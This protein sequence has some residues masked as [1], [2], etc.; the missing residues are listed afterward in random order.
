MPAIP[1]ARY[2]H[3]IWVHLHQAMQG[4]LNV[5]TNK[6]ENNQSPTQN[7]SN[8]KKAAKLVLRMTD[9][10]EDWKQLMMTVINWA[11]HTPV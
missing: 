10:T 7:S 4:M 1:A 11:Q 2:L 8:Q 5:Q 9:I 3:Y 6:S